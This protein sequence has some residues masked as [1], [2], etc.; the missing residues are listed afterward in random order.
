MRK[1]RILCV[2]EDSRLATGYS[3]H[4]YEL[5]RRFHDA[6][7]EVAELSV[8][9]R[10]EKWPYPWK[11]YIN[12]PTN[13]QE[14]EAYNS[15]GSMAE[16]GFWKFEDVCLDFKPDICISV[17][18]PWMSYEHE[19][20]FRH[21]LQFIYQPTVDTDPQN[22]DWL[23]QFEKSDKLLTFSNFAS[24]LLGRQ[25]KGLRN[26]I[27]NVA[28][29]CADT[30][31]FRPMNKQAIKQ[32]LG[33]PP[34]AIVIGSVMRN[35]KRKLYPDL[36][37]SYWRLNR[38]LID[39][40]RED[41]VSRLY[42]HLHCMYPDLGWDIPRKLREWGGNRVLFTY[43]CDNCKKLNFMHFSGTSD[44]CECGGIQHLPGVACGIS[45][46]D[47]AKVY[48]TYDL[49]V[50]YANCLH[51]DS[52]VL[53]K[54]GWTRI[55]D[56]VVGDE[57]YTH[58]GRW[59]PVLNKF[60]YEKG[61]RPLEITLSGDRTPLIITSKHKVWA[62][63]E[64]TIENLGYKAT[65][66]VRESI[67]RFENFGRTQI[68]PEFIPAEDLKIGDVLVQTICDDVLDID[69]IQIPHFTY[70]MPEFVNVDEYFC[71]WV[72]YYVA[73]GSSTSKPG[74]GT[75]RLTSHKDA[76][77][78]IELSIF[79]IKLITGKDSKI[80]NYKNR[81]AVDVEVYS[82][83][84][85]NYLIKECK[86]SQEKMLPEWFVYLPLNKQKAALQ[87]LFMGDGS[88][89]VKKGCCGYSTIS[90]KLS[91][92]ISFILKR[93]RIP[94]T[95]HKLKRGGNR[96]PCW[97]FEVQCN[98]KDG[99]FIVDKSKN[100]C[101]YYR[102][103][104]VYTKIK[105]IKVSDYDGPVYDF[106]VDEDHSYLW[107]CSSLHNSEGTGV[108]L[109]EAAACGV[110]IMATNYSAMESF[111]Q[112]TDSIPIEVLDYL[113]E[114]ESGVYRA[115][116]S[117]EDFIKKA[118]QFLCK[119]YAMRVAEGMK[120]REKYLEYYD[121]DKTARIWMD[122]FEQA[123]Y[124]DWKKPSKIYNKVPPQIPPQ[125]MKNGKV[126]MVQFVDWVTQFYPH[127]EYERLQILKYLGIGHKVQGVGNMCEDSIIFARVRTE[128]YGAEQVI[129]HI[130][131]KIDKHNFWENQ[132]KHRYGI[133]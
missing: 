123:P 103:N 69:K 80:K 106:E 94:Y 28:P 47:L 55:E 104:R 50:Q 131:W 42:L 9:P 118:Y 39:N 113:P 59:K 3:V 128:P 26:K 90:E 51:P 124:A 114:A 30:N 85:A 23:S 93:L 82:K 46:E 8:Y 7:Y 109:L 125:L 43:F 60:K 52:K 31:T 29:I 45:R 130:N 111:V 108:P 5:L 99:D 12:N 19:S 20:P 40:G 41:I 58:K 37:E 2:N 78:N 63:N 71:K 73:N 72:G 34:N 62:I 67:R 49:Y 18:D 53:L 16:F 70:Y 65:K 77:K 74:T 27:H 11:Q 100:L 126:D 122:L 101:M 36:L 83:V 76:L 132:R 129:N 21:I 22:E 57:A 115:H 97:R 102:E 1:K 87:G 120:G 14:Q 66:G 17:R 33:L 44:Y 127:T 15:M 64:K 112:N 81:K 95:M 133:S 79:G 24:K 10:D 61:D 13:P 117:K 25:H 35:Q 121:W 38:K 48:N 68:E 105:S 84:L 86:K 91:E 98:I 119:P 4:G 56:V 116:P 88:W 110:R 54:R 75:V 6:G 96:K 92:Q 107:Q 32:S 89:S